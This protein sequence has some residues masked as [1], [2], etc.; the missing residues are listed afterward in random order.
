MGGGE[1]REGMEGGV[2]DVVVEV[3]AEGAEDLARAAGLRL[4]LPPFF[5][6]FMLG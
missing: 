5:L 6:R 2:M 4:L 3:V 1:T